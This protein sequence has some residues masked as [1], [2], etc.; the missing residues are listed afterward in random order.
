MTKI[1][2][3]SKKEFESLTKEYRAK[4]FNIITFT[5]KLIE[6]EKGNEIIIIER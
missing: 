1:I 3:K 6:L 2:A 5:K 4:G